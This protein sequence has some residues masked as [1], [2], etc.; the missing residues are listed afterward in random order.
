[1]AASDA[2]YLKVTDGD[3]TKHGTSSRI[4]KASM[5]LLGGSCLVLFSVMAASNYT[6]TAEA[7]TNLFGVTSLRKAN[8]LT[9][10]QTIANQLPGSGPWK[11]LALAAIQDASACHDPR[12]ISA[13]ANVKAVMDSMDSK[14]RAMV[15]ANVQTVRADAKAILKSGSFPPLGFFDPLGFSTDIP[16]GRLLFFREVELKHSRLC[17]LASLGFIVQEKFAPLLGANPDIPSAFAGSGVVPLQQG[18]WAAVSIAMLAVEINSIKWYDQDKSLAVPPKY[19]M[20]A[21]RVPGDYGYDPMGLKPKTEADLI[22]MQNKELANGRLAM[23]AIT[24]MLAQ[25]LVTGQKLDGIGPSMWGYGSEAAM[26]KVQ[27]LVR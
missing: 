26:T 25:E 19:E 6:S 15:Q 27:S 5:A 20:K 12:D 18:F 11:D 3:E 4:L 8:P 17:M 21:D 1:M 10:P 22:S 14:T 9:V 7:T 16:E 2:I 24:G 13:N 23:I